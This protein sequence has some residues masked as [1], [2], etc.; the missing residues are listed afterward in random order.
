MP[1]IS[2][3]YQHENQDKSFDYSRKE[4]FDNRMKQLRLKAYQAMKLNVPGTV[5]VDNKTESRTI[6]FQELDKLRTDLRE[7]S[8]KHYI[9]QLNNYTEFYISHD[10]EISP[11][12]SGI[13]ATSAIIN[14]Q[15][16][17]IM[18]TIPKCGSSSWRKFM[19]YLQFPFLTTSQGIKQYKTVYKDA[20]KPNNPN[21]DPHAIAKNGVKLIAQLNA[22]DA[23]EYYKNPNY[24]KVCLSHSNNVDFTTVKC[25][26]Y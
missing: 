23:L 18:C 8:K 1:S 21:P 7:Q 15:H 12:R 14:D 26:I 5:D 11:K 19:L 3:M 2:K 17:I 24:L 16:N 13:K 6:I 25:I 10:I 9:Q 20:F 4:S 22:N